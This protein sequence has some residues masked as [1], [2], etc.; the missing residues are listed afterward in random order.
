MPA[1]ERALCPRLEMIQGKLSDLR[2]TLRVIQEAGDEK[3]YG[4]ALIEYARALGELEP[5][6]DNK[7][8]YWYD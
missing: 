4:L 6:S 7:G 8:R 3:L 5:Y 2:R 1:K